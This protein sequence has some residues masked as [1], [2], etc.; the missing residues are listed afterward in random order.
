VGSQSRSAA[1]LSKSKWGVL[2]ISPHADR[3]RNLNNL[4][5]DF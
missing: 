3:E 1:R 4:P 2:N 5:R